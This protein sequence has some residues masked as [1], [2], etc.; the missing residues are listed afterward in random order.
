MSSSNLKY[1][2][3]NA[4]SASGGTTTSSSG[5][6]Q[7]IWCS[8][9]TPSQIARKYASIAPIWCHISRPRQLKKK[10]ASTFHQAQSLLSR[11]H[12]KDNTSYTHSN[13]NASTT[14]SSSNLNRLGNDRRDNHNNDDDDDDLATDLNTYKNTAAN[15]NTSNWNPNTMMN[16]ASTSNNTSTKSNRINSTNDSAYDAYSSAATNDYGISLKKRDSSSDVK[17][18]TKLNDITSS[19]IVPS[20]GNSYLYG[21]SAASTV[22]STAKWPSSQNKVLRPQYSFSKETYDNSTSGSGVTGSSYYD[23][24]ALPASTVASDAPVTSSSSSS[25]RPH[26]Y[27]SKY[28]SQA[29]ASTA[30][31]GSKTERIISKSSKSSPN[32]LCKDK[33]YEHFYTSTADKY[34]Q[35]LPTSNSATSTS[36]TSKYHNPYLNSYLSSYNTGTSTGSGSGSSHPYGHSNLNPYLSSNYTN[37]Y[38]QPSSSSNHHHH[39]TYHHPTTTDSSH[40]YN[41]NRE[42][43][44]NELDSMLGAQ[45]ALLSRLESDFVANRNKLKTNPNLT[46]TYGSTST[47]STTGSSTHHPFR[48]TNYNLPSKYL[49]SSTA[50]TSNN[51]NSSINNSTTTA[52]KT[53]NPHIANSSSND[54]LLSAYLPNR[55]RTPTSNKKPASKFLSKYEDI[56]TTLS[57]YYS[58]SAANATTTGVSARKPP[59]SYLTSTKT[60]PL[61]DLINSLDLGDESTSKIG[62]KS[63]NNINQNGEITDNNDVNEAELKQEN[64]VPDGKV[65]QEDPLS[66]GT[67]QPSATMLPST[68][69]TVNQSSVVLGGSKRNSGPND[70]VDDFINDYI[71]NTLLKSDLNPTVTTNANVGLN[72]QSSTTSSSSTNNNGHGS[73]EFTS[74]TSNS[75]NTNIDE[76]LSAIETI[77]KTTANYHPTTTTTTTANASASV[78][79]TT[80]TATSSNT[81]SGYFSNNESVSN[82]ALH[83]STALDTP[84]GATNAASTVN[85]HH[86][87]LLSNNLSSQNSYNSDFG[88]LNSADNSW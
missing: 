9:T 5:I 59:L 62:S 86:H 85:L 78:L 34:D 54:D 41:S 31:G 79:P 1:K 23:D 35:T 68:S 22:G 65:I 77:D 46:G 18:R 13:P 55:Y 88:F 72:Q 12:S 27:N 71:N 64:T 70:F 61:I 24:N 84:I 80:T 26:K 45:S 7:P 60:E 28:T 83:D 52:S 67:Q 39:H 44:W 4:T 32:L 40:H 16:D 47:A 10:F 66:T 63:N 43:K 48:S 17:H 30:S 21:S 53:T 76:A 81:N 6:S 15:A 36:T 57:S 69:A 25:R 42:E 38:Y 73:N 14:N 8:L 49:S 20:S 2:S 50:G 87:N 11:Q 33:D 29:G 51:N 74:N 58:G 75:L 37:N 19:S 82:N 56:D 3:S